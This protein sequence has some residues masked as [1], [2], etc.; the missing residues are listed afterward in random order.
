MLFTFTKTL[1]GK[2]TTVKPEKYS[3]V[4][5]FNGFDLPVEANFVHSLR[6]NLYRFF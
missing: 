1:K 5:I 3:L 4:P 2:A 6:V